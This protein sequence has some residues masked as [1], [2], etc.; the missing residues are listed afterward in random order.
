M[1]ESR[2]GTNGKRNCEAEIELDKTYRHSTMWKII[3][4]QHNA[5]SF[6]MG[7]TGQKE[8]GWPR[9]SWRRDTVA[10]VAGVSVINGEGKKTAGGEERKKKCQPSDGG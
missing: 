4:S 3:P 5:A 6:S 9:N 2:S 10:S 8:W 1:V 7:S